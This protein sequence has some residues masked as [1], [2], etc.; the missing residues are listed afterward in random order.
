MRLFLFLL[1]AYGFVASSAW[2][3]ALHPLTRVPSLSGQT[4]QFAMNRV[5]TCTSM[6]SKNPEEE[7]D[8]GMGNVRQ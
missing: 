1:V 7:E 4:P 2:Q 6:I 3:P 5:K 8:G